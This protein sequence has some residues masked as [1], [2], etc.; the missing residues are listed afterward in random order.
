MDDCQQ[1]CVSPIGNQRFDCVASSKLG[2]KSECVASNSGK[3]KTMD[4]CQQGCVSPIGNQR[5]DCVGGPKIGGGNV[6][7]VPSDSGKFKTMA[8]C[9]KVCVSP[10]GPPDSRF[11]PYFSQ[12]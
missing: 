10:S 1:G 5:F 8:D 11:A 12:Y 4:D 7:C 2:G 3:F 6:Q 9:K